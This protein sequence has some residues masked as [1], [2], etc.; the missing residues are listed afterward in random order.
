MVSDVYLRCIPQMY[1]SY[2]GNQ[3]GMSVT[4]LFKVELSSYLL[5]RFLGM[6]GISHIPHR[7]GNLVAMVTKRYLIDSFV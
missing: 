3:S 2:H 5:W 7:H 1:T 4:G 6:I